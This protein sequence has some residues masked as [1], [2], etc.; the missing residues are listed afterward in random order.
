MIFN[1]TS[2]LSNGFVQ[3]V[4]LAYKGNNKWPAAGTDKYNRILMVANRK[5]RELSNDGNRNW[6]FFWQQVNLADDEY[7]TI[8]AGVQAYGFEPNDASIEVIKP[9]ESVYIDNSDGDQIAVFTIV[10]PQKRNLYSNNVCFISGQNPL[11]LN[12]AGEITA[13][14]SI[15]GG[16]IRVP[17]YGRPAALSAEDDVIP[18][19][20]PEWLVYET[21]AELARNDPAKATQFPNLQGKA[22]D[23]YDKLVAQNDINS[24][25]QP[26]RAEPRMPQIGVSW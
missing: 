23:M 9:A 7:P 5:I 16:T 11:I 19:P 1:D 24:F 20:E 21:A 12:F 3:Q 8:T 25:D 15:V 22:N 6:R 17:V 26:N 4:W 18:L 13:T 10:D 14:D 2:T